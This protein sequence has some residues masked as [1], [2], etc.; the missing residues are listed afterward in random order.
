MKGIHKLSMVNQILLNS[1]F[2]MKKKTKKKKK[3]IKGNKRTGISLS[4]PQVQ[5][6]SNTVWVT[7]HE[8]QFRMR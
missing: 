2:I 3:Q 8:I 6:K 5:N 1:K 4:Y 7:Q